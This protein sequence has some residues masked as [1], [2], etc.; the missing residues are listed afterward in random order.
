[1]LFRSIDLLEQGLEIYLRLQETDAVIQTSQKLIKHL[2]KVGKL[3]RAIEKIGFLSAFVDPED[4]RTHID[5]QIDYANILFYKNDVTQS[6]VIADLCLEESQNARYVEGELRAA[7]TKC[8]CLISKSDLDEHLK[9]L[10][11]YLEI[12]IQ[13]GDL[14]QQAVFENERGINYLYK[15]KFDDSI[16]AF[17]ISL[18]HY[19]SIEDDENI[20][21]AYNN[22]GVIYLDG[23]GDYTTARDY[24]RKAYTR[25]TNKNY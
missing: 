11:H 25:A 3:D 24:F 8:K 6:E 23:Y 14:F 15:N 1:M 20:V 16:E 18:K 7:Y 10:M 12:S 2:I 19:K 13:L 4:T 17:T 22:F 21:K 5:I 9:V